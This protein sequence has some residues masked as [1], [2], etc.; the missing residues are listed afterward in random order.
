MYVQPC[1][2]VCHII[3]L[4]HAHVFQCYIKLVLVGSLKPLL[5]QPARL[6]V[7]LKFNGVTLSARC[8]MMFLP[9]P[10]N[11][12]LHISTPPLYTSMHITNVI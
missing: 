5:C 12:E 9:I 2:Y 3:P 7:K 6:Q 8:A 10:D 11:S 4:R 1:M